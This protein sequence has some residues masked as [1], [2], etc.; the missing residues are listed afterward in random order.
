MTDK[1]RQLVKDEIE[2]L[3]NETD[4]FDDAARY[5]DDIASDVGVD[6]EEVYEELKKFYGRG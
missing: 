5:I 3:A 2:S 6:V 1:Q 4:G